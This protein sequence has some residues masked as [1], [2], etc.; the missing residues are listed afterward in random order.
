MTNIFAINWIGPFSS[1]EQLKSWEKSN[2]QSFEYS[3]YIIT[4]KQISKKKSL[5][6]VELLILKKATCILVL[7]IKHIKFINYVM[8]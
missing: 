3:F 5:N 4:G 6:I 1:V 2:N 8:K 7:M